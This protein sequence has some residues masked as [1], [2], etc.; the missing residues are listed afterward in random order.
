MKSDLIDINEKEDEDVLVEVTLEKK[1]TLK[2][3][4]DMLPRRK[5]E[6]W[7]AG[8][9]SK[10]WNDSSPRHRKDAAPYGYVMSAVQTTLDKI[11]KRNE[12]L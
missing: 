4:W 10:L 9:W 11:L 3:L 1:F 2:E 7:T 12:V 5:Q 8:D 6:G